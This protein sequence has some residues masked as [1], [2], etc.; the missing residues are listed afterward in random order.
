MSLFKYLSQHSNTTVVLFKDSDR[1][2]TAAGS[3]V[4]APHQSGLGGRT[5]EYNKFLLALL[6]QPGPTFVAFLKGAILSR[7]QSNKKQN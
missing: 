1:S 4:P 6:V 3:A 5:R 7:E 2:C